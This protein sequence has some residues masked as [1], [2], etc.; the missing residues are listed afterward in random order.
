LVPRA[1]VN[2]GSIDLE[3]RV[4]RIPPILV[5]PN[6]KWPCV[7]MVVDVFVFSASGAFGPEV[8]SAY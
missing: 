4:R 5:V 3:I 8:A 6:L 1:I 2:A 7:K